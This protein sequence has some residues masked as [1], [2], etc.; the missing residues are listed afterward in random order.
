MAR[1]NIE[2]SLWSKPAFQ[3]FMI[4]MGDRHKA[5]GQV[6][7]LWTL[8][9]AHWFPYRELI[10]ES[11]F[12]DA[13]LSEALIET[14]LAERRDGGIYAKGSEDAFEWLFQNQR[15]GRLGGVASAKRRRA[16]A[17]QSL[18]DDQRNEPSSSSSSSSS[19]T[20]TDVCFLGNEEVEAFETWWR[21]WPNKV[22]HGEALKAFKK[23]KP[24]I[25][26]L[27]TATDKYKIKKPGWQSYCNGA[28]FIN[29]KYKDVL[30]DDYGQDQKP[31]DEV[32]Q[33]MLSV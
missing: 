11:A 31:N 21:S 2:T 3:K 24:P 20:N 18:S 7:D 23:K 33:R 28:T 27:L 19:N 29:S 8:A 25:A 9:Q 13:E 22:D 14:G 30:R 12:H 6:V 17:K 10:P 32:R 15:A 1:L 16:R 4:K 26:E 5:M